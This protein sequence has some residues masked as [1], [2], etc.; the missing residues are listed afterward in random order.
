MPSEDRHLVWPFVRDEREIEFH[1]FR[2]RV[3]VASHPSSGAEHEFT[4]LD[5]ADWANTIAITEDDEVVLIRQ[6]RHGTDSVTLE[7][8]GGMVDDGETHADAAARELLEETGYRAARWHEIGR[9]HPNPALQSNMCSTWLAE[10]AQ[11]VSNPALDEAEAIEVVTAPLAGIR[12]L[13]AGGEITHALVVSAF[14]F[15]WE[16]TST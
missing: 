14:Y 13:I 1:M 5:G 6:F 4:V 15:L 8:P 9:V 10:G 16:H 11:R 2:A 7:I 3:K 12:S